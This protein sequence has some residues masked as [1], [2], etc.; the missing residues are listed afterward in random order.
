MLEIKNI[1]KDY[2]TGGDKV[3]AL[4]DVSISFRDCELVAVLGHSGCGKTTLL[5]IIGGLDQYTTGDLIINGRSTKQYK[6]RDW[7]T[8][9]NHSVGFIFQSYNLIPHQTVLANVELALTLSGVSKSERRQR[10][11]EALE[12]VGLG[13]QL[14]KRPNQMSGGQMQRVAIA[15]ALVN[16][17]EILLAD[18]PTGALDSET[19]V[20]IMEL[21]KEI[22]KDRLV[23]MVTHNPDLANDYATRIVRLVDG[24]IKSD[25]DP[26]ETAESKAEP[27]KSGKK[28]SMSFGTALALSRN[29]LLTKKGRT[30]LTSFAGSIGIIGIALILSLSHGV[31]AYIDGVE[32]STLASY[33]VELERETI[34][35]SGLMTS[36]LDIHDEALEEEREPDRV[37]TNDMSTEMMKSLLSEV[38]ENDLTAFMDY[39]DTNPDNIK[40][41]ISEIKYSYDSSLYVYARGVND[42]IVRVNPSTTMQAM[43]GEGMASGMEDM[44]G[45]A[46]TFMGGDM[47]SRANVFQELISNEMTADQ[48]EVVAG[49]L[50]EKYDE[51]VVIISEHNELSNL[52][53]YTLGLRDQA[54]LGE[55]M[56][57]VIAGETFDL[58]TGDLSFTYD[59]LMALRFKLLTAPELFAEN[60]DGG[61]DNMSG[62]EEFMAKALDNGEE[63]KVV[64]VI[65]P[66]GD[67]LIST[68][69]TGGV[70]YTAALTE[71]MI[72][73]TNES[74][75]VKKQRE[76]PDIDVFTGIE[77]PTKDEEPEEPMSMEEA[78]EQLMGF[79]TEEQV[80]TMSQSIIET[81]TDEQKMQLMQLPPEQQQTA[82]FTMAEQTKITAAFMSVITA[83]QM[84]QLQELTKEPETT[85]ATYDGNLQ[86]LGVADLQIPSKVS[87]YARDFESKENITNLISDY[88]NKKAAE[89]KEKDVINYTDYVGMM[90]ASVSDTIDAISYILIAFV[91]ISLVVSSIMIGIITYISV[92]E[93]TKEI[94]IL[95]AMGASKHD[96]SNVFNAETLIVG[97]AAGVIGILV[98]LILNIPINI[99]IEYVTDIPNMAK[100]PWQGGLILILISMLLTLIAGLFPASIAAKKD[101]VEALRTE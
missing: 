74:A 1:T 98:T 11:K 67:S 81:L 48:Y 18:E 34:N 22:A 43:L 2:D 44:M 42:E 88:N 21:V 31:Q 47:S 101:P 51:L 5:N 10:A 25:S 89:G 14:N 95:R 49:R 56:S 29:N 99:I 54:E 24:K 78:M 55:M 23:I 39:I 26:Y 96:V 70:G 3:H 50:P 75:L 52:T 7:D 32:R 65:R 66:N 59:E 6:D 84:Q 41:S 68:S 86:I 12:K 76:N 19:S 33:P 82:I 93:R 71:H 64:G 53:L 72:N 17:P 38:Q 27:K 87:I 36:M 79:M 94:G 97:F 37:Y 9:R 58:D 40:D 73:K 28:T 69:S 20:Q 4:R 83:E 63:L 13:D 8:Y 90:I 77:F 35:Y 15:R 45:M 92:L 61:Y 91:A 80:M 46:S 85:E 60:E 57:H 16:D 30:F 62:D 100:L